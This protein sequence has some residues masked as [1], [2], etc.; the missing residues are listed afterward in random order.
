[1]HPQ[2]RNPVLMGGARGIG[3]ESF[4]QLIHIL[5]LSFSLSSSPHPTHTNTETLILNFPSFFLQKIHLYCPLP[6]LHHMFADNDIAFQLAI[7]KALALFWV[8]GF[9]GSHLSS[10]LLCDFTSVSL[11]FPICETRA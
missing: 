8:L 5:S 6:L 1:M 7:I 4:F 10:E 11:H 3:E 9:L 2:P